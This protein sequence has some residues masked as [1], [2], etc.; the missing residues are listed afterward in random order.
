MRNFLVIVLLIIPSWLVAQQWKSY[1]YSVAVF[2]NATMMPLPSLVA[3]TNQP[4]HP[5]FLISS[6]FGWKERKKHKW[7]QDINLGYMYHRLAFQSILLYTKAGFRQEFCRFNA[8]ASLQ[9]G[10]MHS[11][12]LTDRLVRQDDGSYKSETGWGKPQF[13]TGAG[14]AVGYNFGKEKIRR[15]FLSYDFKIQMPFVKSYV[16]FLPN[17]SLGVG[18]QFTF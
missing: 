11:F 10:Y 13:I 17:G 8:D 6:E 2:N 3:I 15:I 16:T 4:I 7:F 14:L 1:P 18:F 9:A 12:M 5:G